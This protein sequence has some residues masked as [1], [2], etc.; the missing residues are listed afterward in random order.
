MTTQARK[1]SRWF[2]GKANKI[3]WGGLKRSR[4]S[5]EVRLQKT[6][7]Q[8]SLQKEQK[9]CAGHQTEKSYDRD[10]EAERYKK[11]RKKRIYRS[12]K[13]LGQKIGKGKI[14]EIADCERQVG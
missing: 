14:R 6:L 13:E 10:A 9:S 1:P 4:K 2:A 5:R 8:I 3:G 7:T 12:R 11:K